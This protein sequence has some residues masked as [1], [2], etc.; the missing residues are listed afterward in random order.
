MKKIIFTAIIAVLCQYIAHA[1]VTFINDYEQCFTSIKGVKG[2]TKDLSISVV[3]NEKDTN[4]IVIYG[5]E[6][7]KRFHVIRIEEGKCD[8]GTEYQLMSCIDISNGEERLVQLFD[9]ALRIF[10][11]EDYIEYH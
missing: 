3:F 5:L 11:K 9:E 10:I 4:N 8:D 2:E 1:Q 6:E 7:I